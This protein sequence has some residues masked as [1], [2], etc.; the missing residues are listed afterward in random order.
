VEQLGKTQFIQNIVELIYFGKKSTCLAYNILTK[1]C[2]TSVVGTSHVS[3][4][5]FLTQEFKSTF[6]VPI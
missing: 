2:F 3:A 5:C 1:L 6:D 4:V